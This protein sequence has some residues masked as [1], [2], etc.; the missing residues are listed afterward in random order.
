MPPESRS[1]GFDYPALLRSALLGLVRDL[2]RGVVERGLPGDHHFYLTFHTDAPGAAL[3][4]R[5]RRQFPQEMTIVLQ[6]QFQDLQVGD[7]SF[8]VTLRFGGRP[9]R[10]TVPFAAL[11]AFV[12]PPASFGLRF[13]PEQEAPSVAAATPAATEEPGDKPV[14]R[15]PGAVLPFRPRPGTNDEEAPAW[16]PNGGQDETP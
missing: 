16:P 13:D 10:L 11:S 3:S 15:A 4:D 6:H 14:S 12:D 5:L 8:S 1:P 9:E 2:L 7:D